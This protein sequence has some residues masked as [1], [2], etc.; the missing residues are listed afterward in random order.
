M[1]KVLFI[2]STVVMIVAAVY[3]YKNGDEFKKARQEAIAANIK[4]EAERTQALN[5]EKEVKTVEGSLANVQ[6]ELDVESEKK[7]AQQLRVAQA[8]NE[9]KQVQ[10]QLNEQEKKLADLR[11]RLDKLPQGMNSDNL[12]ESINGMKKSIADMEAQVEAKKK[13]I[14]AVQEKANE[15]QKALDEVVRKIEERKKAFDRNSL[16][17]RIVAVNRDW[18]FVIIDAG[19]S[20]GITE[21]TKLL[22]ARGMQTVGKLNIISVQ[23]DRTVANILPETLAQGMSIQPGDRVILE[24]LYQ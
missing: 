2:L 4:V 19:E 23:G 1:T 7:K 11:L 24:N 10:E 12:V 13:D 6:Q 9:A 5:A 20:Q 21:A 18:G 3:A 22:V 16:T 15:A 17:A 14:A 8:E